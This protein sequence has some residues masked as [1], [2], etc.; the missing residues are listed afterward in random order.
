MKNLK[1][2]LSLI[3]SFS[4]YASDDMYKIGPVDYSVLKKL[5]AEKGLETIRNDISKYFFFEKTPT[6]YTIEQVV[7]K[8]DNSEISKAVFSNIFLI[9]HNTIALPNE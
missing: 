2:C 6:P 4:L 3:I 8:M 5:V 7:T 9:Y 1:L